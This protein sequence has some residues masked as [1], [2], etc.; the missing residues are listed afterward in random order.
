MMKKLWQRIKRLL[1]LAKDEDLKFEKEIKEMN[2][3]SIGKDIF[4]QLISFSDANLVCAM[5]GRICIG[6]KAD[7]ERSKR[8]EYIKRVVGRGHT[9]V[10]AHSSI[11]MLLEY[12][13]PF[14][15]YMAECIPAF[16]FLNTCV[17]VNKEYI[18]DGITNRYCTLI[19]GSIRAYR[20]LVQHS[21]INNPIISSIINALYGACEKEFFCDIIDDE[22]MSDTRFGFSPITGLK[23]EYAPIIVNGEE[24]MEEGVTDTGDYHQT[25]TT[26]QSVDIVYSDNPYSIHDAVKGYGFTIEDVLRVSS[27]TL[28]FHDVSRAISQQMVRHNAGISQESQR[29]VDYSKAQFI[30]PTIFDSDRYN[31]SI[32][33]K[34]VF[35]SG[36]EKEYTSLELG[37]ALKSIYSQLVNQGMLKQDARGYLPFNVATKLM[38]TFTFADLI[39]FLNMRLDKAAQPEIRVISEEIV[40]LLRSNE[41]TSD[42]MEM[43]KLE[44]LISMI[45]RP[46]Y[47]RFA[48]EMLASDADV[49]EVIST[50]EEIIETPRNSVSNTNPVLTKDQMDKASNF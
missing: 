24:I 46:Y 28:R 20:Y 38:M 35:D 11:V 25:E 21:D 36:V 10:L 33:Y 26:G 2:M 34:I 23:T 19:G 3:Q 37:N 41:E 50:S 31:I 7:Q 16:K 43:N 22:A 1:G 42:L 18:E 40:E 39:H 27:I 15:Q 45:E 6:Q 30:D 47:K 4:C 14:A 13:S 17:S 48:D 5:A 8:L 29:Y 49:D 9:S 32:G 12:D 44:D